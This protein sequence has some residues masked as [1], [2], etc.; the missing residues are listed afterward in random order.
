MMNWS[1]SGKTHSWPNLRYYSGIF[2]KVLRK[3]MKTSVRIA[4]VQAKIRTREY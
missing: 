3:T 1:G 4:T 2:M